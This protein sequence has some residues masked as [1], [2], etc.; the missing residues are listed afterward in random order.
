MCTTLDELDAIE[1][2]FSQAN[3]RSP[4]ML[5]TNFILRKEKRFASLKDKISNGDLGVIYSIEASYDYGRIH[6]ILNGWR[7]SSL[8]YSV[9]NGGGIHMLDLCQW[10]AGDQFSPMFALHN[11]VITEGTEF[12]APDFTSALGRLGSQTVCKVTANFGSQTPHYHQLKVYGTKGTFINDCAEGT[13]F[14]GHEPDVIRVS[15]EH[16]FPCANKGDLL[17]NFV[18]A[19]LGCGALDVGFGEVASVMRTSLV[20]DQL[21]AKNEFDG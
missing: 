3:A 8:N 15:D 18:D 10:L 11:K 12:R 14:F 6:K 20:I 16:P 9:M 2:E 1:H 21:A 19:I 4:K 7:G 5:S 17:P 13:Y